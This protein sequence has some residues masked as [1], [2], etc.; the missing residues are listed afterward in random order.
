MRVAL[1]SPF[2]GQGGIDE[3]AAMLYRQLRQRDI[4]VLPFGEPNLADSPEQVYRQVAQ[5]NVPVLILNYQ[6]AVSHGWHQDS[7]HRWS[8]EYLNAFTA[9]GVKTIVIFHDTFGEHSLNWMDERGDGR[10][11]LMADL[12]LTASAF[13]VHEPCIGFENAKYWR[14]GIPEPQPPEGNKAARWFG[15]P[16][17]GSNGFPMLHKNYTE[18][19][20]CTA[21]AGWGLL[22]LAPNATEAMIEEWTAINPAIEVVTEYLSTARGVALLTGCDATAYMYSGATAG[23]SGAIRWGIAARKPVIALRGQRQF[24][25]LLHGDFAA[26]IHGAHGTRGSGIHWVD[27]FTDLQAALSY[28]IPIQRVDPAMVAR[29]EYDSWTNL[30]AKFAALCQEFA[31]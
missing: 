1:V 16:V 11:H 2:G 23:T 22:L 21:A 7:Q 15:Q 19:A 9:A 12:Y 26:Q 25:D 30:G 20:R 28:D 27:S 8:G 14:Q 3:Y 4:T 29:A 6:G 24:R 13:V 31:P 5:Q 17:L 18:L 10:L